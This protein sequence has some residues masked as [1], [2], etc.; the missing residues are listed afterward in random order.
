LL[1][2]IEVLK[3]VMYGKILKT[4]IPCAF[5]D[6]ILSLNLIIIT[7]HNHICDYEQSNVIYRSLQKI[8]FKLNDQEPYI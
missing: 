5:K 7:I 6:I 2:L 4:Y 3:E 8:S 1:L